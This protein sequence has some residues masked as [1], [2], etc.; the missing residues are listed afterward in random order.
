M[1]RTVYR[2][3]YPDLHAIPARLRQGRQTIYKQD[4]VFLNDDDD[5]MPLNAIVSREKAMQR[6][7]SYVAKMRH[8]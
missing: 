6:Y 1:V 7:Q 8:L 2:A 3:F 4:T 5:T